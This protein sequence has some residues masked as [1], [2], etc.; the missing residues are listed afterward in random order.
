MFK[1]RYLNL[2][3]QELKTFQLHTLYRALEGVVLGVIALNEY[4]FIRSMMGTN[5]Q[6][7]FLFQF[8]VVV[9]VFLLFFNEIRKRIRNKK[10][11]LRVTALITR[12]PL[13]ILL[14]FPRSTEEMESVAIYH[15]VFLG[16]FLVY[17]LGNIIIFPAINVLLKTNYRHQNFGKLYSYSTS[18]NKLITLVSIFLYGLMLD[19]DQFFY[20]YVFPVVAILDILGVFFLSKIDYSKVIQKVQQGTLGTAVSASFKGIW[21]ILKTNRPYLHFELGFM[22][23]GFSFM[24]S[25]TIINIYFKEALGLNYSSVAFYKNAYNILAILILPFFGRL[26]GNIDPRKFAVITF[27]SLLFFITFTMLTEYLPYH[28]TIWEIDIYMMLIIAY[29]FYGLFAATMVL[30]WNIGSA[31]FCAPEEADDYQSIHLSLTGIRS[32]FAPILGVFIYEMAG[33]TLTFSI[34]ILM[35][36]LAILLMIWSYN[37]DR[38]ALRS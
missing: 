14:F 12:L 3:R 17:Y 33:F 18:L 37:N 24:V 25:H 1:F 27:A 22:L 16:I 30:L 19:A 20:V 11:M 8:S 29:L 32:L 5:Y 34:G 4:V 7:A 36:L 23:Y 31:Y 6:L 15:Y 10:L 13:F 35:I 28:I 38:V 26:L 9:Y 2:N 21:N